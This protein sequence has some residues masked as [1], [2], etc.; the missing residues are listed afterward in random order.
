MKQQQVGESV[1]ERGGKS[2]KE[3]GGERGDPI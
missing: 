3:D 1:W 2:L